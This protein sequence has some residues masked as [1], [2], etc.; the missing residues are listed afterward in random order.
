MSSPSEFLLYSFN[1]LD[2]KTPYDIFNQALCCTV[3]PL[4]QNDIDTNDSAQ[5]FS[6]EYSLEYSAQSLQT[7]FN[8]SFGLEESYAEVNG[9][10][11]ISYTQDQY[12]T[13]TAFNAGYYCTIFCGTTSVKDKNPDSILSLL[14]P[15]LVQS[16]E[17]IASLA[18]A[19]AFTDAW[20]THLI[21]SV[22]LGGSLFI[23]IQAA[24]TT[25]TDQQSVSAS[26]AADYQ[27]ASTSISATAAAAKTVTTSAT[28]A[29]VSQK[30]TA[31]GGSAVAAATI[32]SNDPN[33]F[34][35]W[36]ETCSAETV[37]A[38]NAAVAFSSL[39]TAGSVARS[40][41]EEYV[42]LALLAKS[43]NHPT[44]LYATAS[45]EP[46]QVF[47]VSVSTRKSGYKILG[48]GAQL[49][50][51]SSSFLMGS[52]PNQDSAGA[53][54]SW[55][56]ASHDTGSAASGSLTVYAFAVYDP[57]NHL[58][59]TVQSQA[60]TNTKSGSDEAKATVVGILVGGGGCNVAA[61]GSSVK[62]MLA[63]YPLSPTVWRSSCYDYINKASNSALTSYAVGIV[64]SN[65]LSVVPTIVT[66]IRGESEHGDSQAICPSSHGVTGGG[67]Q[68]EIINN[69]QNFL[70]ASYPDTLHSWRETN[71]DANGKK[72]DAYHTAYAIYLN[73]SVMV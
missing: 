62:F 38:L 19:K 13:S 30:I 37:Q 61:A 14:Q 69:A 59:V 46:Y 51:H 41:L 11:Q 43:L 73:A 57:Y 53:I 72:A 48:G 67:A 71:T 26:V 52:Y 32:N 55:V 28:T 54:A 7:S 22:K 63:S 44:S 8:S 49:S 27:S 40:L 16:L 18:D 64:P 31:Y 4:P 39:L 3:N 10:A 60:G 66:G 2:L 20:G 70:Q 68:L 6:G 35:Q 29:S 17:G 45:L 42:Q 25:T 21:T 33:T 12:T 1:A 9:S 24:T 23:A 47:S 65:N 36:A 50:P 34:N 15:K 58:A 56:A 5:S